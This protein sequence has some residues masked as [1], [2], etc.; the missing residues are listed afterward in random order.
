MKKI[1]LAIL[2][3]LLLLNIQAQ[4]HN[5]SKK[6][7]DKPSVHGMLIFGTEKFYASHL[8]M[9]HTPHDYQIILE[10]ALVDS[11]R[12][13]FI[14]DQIENPEYATYTIV[15][16]VFVLP[17]KVD[18]MG[19]FKAD[20]YRGHFE[21]GG[22]KIAEKINVKITELVY[23]KKFDPNEKRDSSANFILFGNDKEQFAV[24][25]ISNKPDFEQLIQIAT[26][27][28]RFNSQVVSLS[29]NN[30]P[31][32]VSSNKVKVPQNEEPITLLKQLYLEFADLAY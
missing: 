10:A 16:E 26:D 19:S 24:H 4:H 9:F 20:L 1:I 23:F 15:P 18:E 13:L 7:S 21:R 27:L 32:G 22:N 12:Q 5:H 14:K 28:E 2:Y 31:I 3:F 25:Q 6:Y 17:E 29:K 30:S 8:P 11:V